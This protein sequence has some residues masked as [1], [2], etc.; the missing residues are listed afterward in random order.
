MIQPDV[1]LSRILIAISRDKSISRAATAVGL[2]R[3]TLMRRLAELEADAGV[4]ILIRRSTGIELTG[5]GRALVEAAE[6]IA[7]ATENF[8]RVLKSL[9]V[10]ES[11]VSVSAPEGIASYLLGPQAAG[12]PV[13]ASPLAP[14]PSGTLPTLDILPA[15]AR[16]DIEILH[17]APGCDVP[18]PSE[19][20]ARKLG[21]MRFK[22]VTS[23]KFL[24]ANGSPTLFS[25]LSKFPLIHHSAYCAIP[26]FRQWN[27]IAF[28]GNRRLFTAKT[29][30]ALHRALLTGGG[31][32][33]LPNFSE[34]LDDSVSVLPIGEDASVE[35]WAAAM[36]ETLKL[37]AARRTFDA[38]CAA[39][40]SNWFSA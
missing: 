34:L 10:T 9:V 36:P 8:E 14:I 32:T 3:H 24:E 26:S 1:T 33:M 29:S 37:P 40:G 19:Y 17:V 12:L 7:L 6:A 11:T 22:P 4:P 31:V 35:V 38:I 30:S 27:D 28:G 2:G 20:V 16:A 5:A 39:F 25:D 18:R 13:G 15:D 23:R 21:V